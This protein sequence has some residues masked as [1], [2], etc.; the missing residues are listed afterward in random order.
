MSLQEVSPLK[1]FRSVCP[2]HPGE[3][4]DPRF[5]FLDKLI[6]SGWGSVPMYL[7]DR[8]IKEN[9]GVLPS[10]PVLL[11]SGKLTPQLDELQC[12]PVPREPI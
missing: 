12:T 11:Q 6:N 1:V 2:C 8:A 7:I 10:A 5:T 4:R 9:G 3:V